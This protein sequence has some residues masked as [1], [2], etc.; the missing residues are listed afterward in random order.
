MTSNDLSYYVI[1]AHPSLGRNTR[2]ILGLAQ[3]EMQFVFL[4][5]IKCSIFILQGVRL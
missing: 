3:N 5:N 1:I 2:I 4:K